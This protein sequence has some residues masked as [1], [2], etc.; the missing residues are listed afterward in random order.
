MIPIFNKRRYSI[1][2]QWKCKIMIKQ[3]LLLAGVILLITGCNGN[4][5]QRSANNKLFDT[6][7]FDKSKRKPVYNDKYI[8]RA[9][10]N[11]VENNYDDEELDVDEP[12]EYVDPYTQN[13]IMYSNMVKND[14]KK[15]RGRNND[16]PDIGHARDI[17]KLDDRSD[18]NSDLRQ[19]LNEIKT[20]LTSAKKD[21]TKYKCP[22]QDASANA[23]VQKPKP[24]K[25][26]VKKPEQPKPTVEE[27]SES[28]GNNSDDIDTNADMHPVSAAPAVKHNAGD[29]AVHNVSENVNP[30]PVA[31][32]AP[33]EHIISPASPPPAA[34]QAP[35]AHQPLSH[36]NSSNYHE[37]AD[38]N[39]TNQMVVV[40]AAPGSDHSMIN[41]APAK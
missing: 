38:D 24:K 1:F 12:D 34:E 40:P 20:M 4:N 35:E 36:Q 17:A 13:R 15:R 30:A 6:K 22:L 8:S 11:I 18:A 7:G 2:F 39:V 10:R 25:Q 33:Q 21:L 27:Q 19:E 3:I 31:T 37:V 23:V 41:L 29:P 26:P 9:K 5:L 28:E 14:K 16:Y 32:A